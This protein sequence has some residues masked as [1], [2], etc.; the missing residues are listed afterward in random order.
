MVNPPLFRLLQLRLL[1]T[2]RETARLTELGR[3]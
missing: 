2:H 1:K 3:L